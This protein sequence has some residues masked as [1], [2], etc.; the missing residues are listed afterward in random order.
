[1]SRTQQGRQREPPFPTF[2]RIP[3]A[4]RVEWQNSTPRLTS[5]PERRNGVLEW[6]SNPQPVGST[7]TPRAAAPRLATIFLGYILIYILKIILEIAII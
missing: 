7:V 6:G 1:M 2:C 3:E 5:T 4:L